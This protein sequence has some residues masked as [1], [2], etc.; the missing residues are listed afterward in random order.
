MKRLRSSNANTVC[1]MGQDNRKCDII[2]MGSL[3]LEFPTLRRTNDS[4][5]SARSATSI[6]ASIHNIQRLGL[7]VEFW[8][9]PQRLDR[10]HQDCDVGAWLALKANKLVEEV[11][12]FGSEGQ[13]S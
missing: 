2:N 3:E 1:L 10:T 12:G 7:G 8:P 5:H 11:E 6:L 9:G 13:S 4:I